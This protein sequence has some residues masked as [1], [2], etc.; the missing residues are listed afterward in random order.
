MRKKSAEVGVPPETC[1]SC[2]VRTAYLPS[3]ESTHSLD[4]KIKQRVGELTSIKFQIWVG[5]SR[6]Q[7][8]GCVKT[9][10]DFH[11]QKSIIEQK[12]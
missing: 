2:H 11:F 6:E 4:T 9:D 8:H 7:G 5:R 12:A 3:P 1:N 10:T